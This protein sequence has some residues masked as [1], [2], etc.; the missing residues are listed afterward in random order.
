MLEM[1]KR[2]YDCHYGC[3]VEATLDVIG[4]KWKGV[5]LY[6]LCARKRRYNELRR[7]LPD[8]TQRMLTLALRDLERDGVVRRS[9]YPEAPPRVEYELTTF[10]E[11]LRPIVDLMRDWGAEWKNRIIKT[12][13]RVA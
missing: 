9:V 11:S 4:G 5:I 2:N 3:P 13:Q 12:R 7:L 1:A 8:V 10:G 6:H